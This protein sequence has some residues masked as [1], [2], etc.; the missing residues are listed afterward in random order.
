MPKV[1]LICINLH[2]ND[3]RYS[4][5]ITRLILSHLLQNMQRWVSRGRRIDWK[6]SQCM[7]VSRNTV[8]RSR[9]ENINFACF[10]SRPELRYFLKESCIGTLSNRFGDPE[11]PIFACFIINEKELAALLKNCTENQFYAN[12]CKLGQLWALI[13][14]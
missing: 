9:H 14:H 4:F 7:I 13:S 3:F 11:I 1:G 12:L 8:I 5:S 2:K 6:G 10:V